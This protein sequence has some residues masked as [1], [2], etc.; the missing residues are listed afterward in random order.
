MSTTAPDSR[1]TTYKPTVATID[2]P[3]LFPIFD[4]GD[5]AV[6]HDGEPRTDF[7]VT[8]TYSDG[9]S[10]DAVVHF[11]TGLVG[12]VEVVGL[13]DPHRTNRFGPGPIPTR[14]LN[15]AF[16]TLEGEIQEARRDVDRSHKA[17]L[18]QEGGVFN[19]DQIANAQAYAEAALEALELINQLGTPL[20][21]TVSD[22]KVATPAMPADAIKSSKVGYKS[23]AMGSVNRYLSSRLDDLSY[24][25]KDFGAI[26]DGVADDLAAI[27][28]A[29]DACKAGGGGKVIFPSPINFYRITS[30]IVLDFSGASYL[31]NRF[32]NRVDLEG[33][34][35]STAIVLDNPGAV[36]AITVTGHPSNN[37][38]YFSIGYL[39]LDRVQKLV[40]GS[41]GLRLNRAAFCSARKLVVEGF[42]LAVSG[43]DTEQM[44]FYDCEIRFNNVGFTATTGTMTSP[45]SLSFYNC[46][47]GNNA[48]LGLYVT[49]ANALNFNG[50]SIQYN[51]TIGS[52]ANTGGCYIIDAGNGY[53][54]IGFTNTIF[55]GNG[56]LGDFVSGQANYGSSVSFQN[57]AFTRTASF[58]SATILGASNNGAG[59]IRLT[60]DTTAH[61]VGQSKALITGVVGSVPANSST[62][63]QFNI[64]DAT[65]I[66]LIGSVFSGMYTSGG[67][68]SV[69]GFGANQI[70]MDG[71]HGDVTLSIRDCRFMQ[72]AVYLPSAA[73]PVILL[74]NPLAKIRDDGTNFFQNSVEKTPYTEDKR[75]GDDG[76]SWAAFT[77]TVS[78]ASGTFAA[79][80]S[81]KVKKIGKTVYFSFEVV[82][83]AYTATPAA[84]LTLTLPYV[85][86]VAATAIAM[87]TTTVTDA[88]GVIGAGLATVRIWAGGAFPISANGQRLVVSGCYEAI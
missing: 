69:V 2:F 49:N 68:V 1:I 73:R 8:A 23:S 7:T 67:Q 12:K 59:L 45:N 15:L 4:S 54:T 70:L 19:A 25:V 74:A 87:N 82:T 10:N 71:T 29:V 88:V 83:T 58:S 37:A 79:S 27:Q 47:I 16:D 39:R 78:A 30:P 57:C 62:P 51:G 43:T 35:V 26:G 48:K 44:A 33:Q 6:M 75:I 41:C 52:G 60:V 66:D 17:P 3:T 81:G 42:D 32:R 76:S 34:G 55:E 38:L 77:P 80:A 14:D 28:R 63:W 65:H 11:A 24:N 64:V 56:G 50:G 36:D 18:G 22:P 13:R 40:A 31:S 84:P 20:D 46:A 5:L 86:S 85:A 72:D 9:V 53:G 61:L 21:G